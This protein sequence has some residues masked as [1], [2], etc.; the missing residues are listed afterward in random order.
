MKP[1]I[2]SKKQYT[3]GVRP[4][5]RTIERLV[6][7][8]GDLRSPDI[9]NQLLT[10]VAKIGREHFT[11][12]DLKILNTT[13][14]ELRY[15]FHIFEP[16]RHIRKVAV[17]GSARTKPTE[18]IYK[19]AI[20]F[21]K[22]MADEGWMVIT[23]GS[24]G[25]MRAGHEGSGSALS[26]GLNIRLPFEQEVNPVIKG[27]H[28]LIHFKYFF[29]RKLC[30][31]KESDATVLYPGGFGTHDE[32]MESLTLSQTG[33]NSPRP[34]VLVDTPASNY[35]KKWLDFLKECLIK[36]KLIDPDDYYLVRLAKTP[37]DACK[38]VVRFYQIYHSM[39]YV[40]EVTVFR[41]QKEIT[42]R[43]L[44]ELNKRFSGLL[45]RGKI[46]KSDALAKES[47]EPEILSLPRIKFYF[48][49][50]KFGTLRLLIDALN[51]D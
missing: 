47:D 32:G 20:Q 19:S 28:K 35:W 26:F 15:A 7:M 18:P 49:R 36:R 38:E 50:K 37:Q 13:L 40:D 9:I 33:K 34:I 27:D 11:R 41:L 2:K 1:S 5:D 17:F 12:G 23:G 10:T 30:F 43:K 44:K 48:N 46:T 4:I 21:G 42:P 45:V 6:R 39:R 29:T 3:V 31:I 25:I 16:Y 22:C 24:T 51:S 8:T 14:K